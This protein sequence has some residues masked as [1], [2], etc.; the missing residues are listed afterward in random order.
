MYRLPSMLG[1]AVLQ[2]SIIAIG[3]WINPLLIVLIPAALLTTFLLV[4]NPGITLLL[5][6]LTAIIKG[7]LLEQFLFFEMIDISVILITLLLFGLIYLYITNHF[8][9]PNELKL[10]FYLFIAF[11]FIIFLSGLYTPSPE[12]GWIKI[13]RFIIILLPMFVTPLV[14][15]R[16]NV[17][18]IKLM[19]ILIILFISIITAMLIQLLYV[20]ISGGLMGYLI[21]VSLSGANPISIA[22]YLAIGGALIFPILNSKS[23]GQQ[24]F[25]IIA[26]IVTILVMISTG[27]RG[28]IVSLFLGIISYTLIFVAKDKSILFSYFAFAFIVTIVL[29]LILPE[30]LTYRFYQVTGGDYVLTQTG[31]KRYSTIASRLHFWSLAFTGWSSSIGHLFFGLGA[32]GFSS[33][34]IWRDF[35]WY[36]HNIFLEVLSEFGLIGIALFLTVL[37]LSAWF[38]IKNREIIRIN[39]TTQMWIC[40][41]LVTFFSTLFSGDLN[42]NRIFFMLLSVVL[43][44]VVADKKHY[45]FNKSKINIEFSNSSQLLN[46]K[47]PINVGN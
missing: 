10:I 17:D 39:P 14:L 46:S 2:V 33:L 42:D 28:P 11:S 4:R 1:L 30:N 32:G 41:T 37:I 44:S 15:I 38:I 19:R 26:L 36:P 13:G 20:T 25:L 3:I 21:R 22:R 9:I 23:K 35:R 18:S 24:S 27:S 40:A 47:Q 12:Y 29:I 7:F 31:V 5:L 6:S 8:T 16:S 43:A 45:R 34:F